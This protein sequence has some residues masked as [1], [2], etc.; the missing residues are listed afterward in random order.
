MNSLSTLPNRPLTEEE[1]HAIL[2]ADGILEGR[3]QFV[4]VEDR[5]I[6]GILL[7]LESGT[8]TIV[9]YD[10]E[11]NK[12]VQVMRQDVDDEN[13]IEDDLDTAF[14]WLTERYGEEGFATVGTV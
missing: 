8:A 12:W 9:C 13:A 4:R 1:T 7:I 3:P 11:E 10:P 14:D 2:S 5:Q 6:I